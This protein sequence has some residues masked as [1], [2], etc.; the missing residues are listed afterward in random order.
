MSN[1]SCYLPYLAVELLEHIAYYSASPLGPPSSV[2]A[3]QLTCRSIHNAL[4]F[5]SDRPY[6][7]DRIFRLKFDIQA[8]RRRLGS[9]ILNPSTLAEELR[10]RCAMLQR[11]RAYDM[12]SPSIRDDLWLAYLMLLESDGR[13][14][15]QLIEWAGLRDYALAYLVQSLGVHRDSYGW[16]TE[17][18]EN[19]L[20][21]WLLWMSGDEGKLVTFIFLTQRDLRL[22]FALSYRT[23]LQTAFVVS[24]LRFEVSCFAF[25]N[26]L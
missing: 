11:I 2:L 21:V 4:L 5:S 10:R 9:G 19:A 1:S 3:L 6:L 23:L 14:E 25:C 12:T 13:N 24:Q 17:S 20:A 22:S 26:R 8:P 18:E 7:Y 15:R 16:P